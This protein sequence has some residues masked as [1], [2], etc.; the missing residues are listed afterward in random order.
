MSNL[1]AFLKQ[2]KKERENVKFVA[3]K[4]FRDENG[5]PIEWEIRPLKSKEMENMRA[6]C[7][8]VG[9]KGKNVDFDQTKFSRL[10]SS[11]AT[12]FPDLNDVELQNS[13]GV[14]CAEDLIVE[15]LDI[16]GE[17]SAYTQK[18]LE[19]AGYNK[20]DEELREEVKN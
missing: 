10:Y 6:Q 9:N 13:Y 20:S 17:Y 5:N 15:M 8:K 7:T 11:R 12:V 3:S 1:V 4:D 14:M 18:V 16:D 2:N 19:V